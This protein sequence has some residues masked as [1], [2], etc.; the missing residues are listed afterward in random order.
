MDGAP[1]AQKAVRDVDWME[2]GKMGCISETQW[3]GASEST[4]PELPSLC[5][6]LLLLV[7]GRTLAWSVNCCSDSLA[8]AGPWGALECICWQAVAAT[9]ANVELHFG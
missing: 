4:M 2:N 5:A 3:T 8:P 6:M 7:S 1:E 9:T